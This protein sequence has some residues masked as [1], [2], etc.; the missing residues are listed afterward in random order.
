MSIC[1]KVDCKLKGTRLL[2]WGEECRN[3]TQAEGAPQT[4]RLPH[5]VV[6]GH[7]IASSHYEHLKHP[8][9]HLHRTINGEYER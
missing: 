4:V 8:G 5:N 2:R 1:V 9:T 3:A 7:D 6:K